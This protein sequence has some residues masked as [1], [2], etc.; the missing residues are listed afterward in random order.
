MWNID[1]KI[2]ERA[3]AYKPGNIDC[4]LCLAEKYHI[5]N[6]YAEMMATLC[7][8]TAKILQWHI[9]TTYVCFVCINE[10][11]IIIL[12][13]IDLWVHI[14]LTPLSFTVFTFKQRK[15]LKTYSILVHRNLWLTFYYPSNFFLNIPFYMIL[16]V[17]KESPNILD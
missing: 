10:L 7:V 11:S 2:Q 12:F 15:I 3:Q 5:F 14:I 4:N 8:F 1:W 17:M 9:L 6:E 13:L 16:G